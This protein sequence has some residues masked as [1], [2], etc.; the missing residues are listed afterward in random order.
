MKQN[1]KAQ[2]KKMMRNHDER[3]RMIEVL[4]TISIYMSMLGNNSLKVTKLLLKLR[5]L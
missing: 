4:T 2:K 1:S 5:Y 3:Y